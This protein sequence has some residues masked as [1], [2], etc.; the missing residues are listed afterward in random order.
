MASW[1]WEPLY[2]RDRLVGVVAR[3]DRAFEEGRI[4]K[5]LLVQTAH[6]IALERYN[7]ANPPRQKERVRVK[8]ITRKVPDL[9]D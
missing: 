4:W 3:P 8:A 9:T 5:A 1:E 7:L 6:A 2:Y